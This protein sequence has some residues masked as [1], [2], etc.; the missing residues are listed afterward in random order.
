MSSAAV[1][2]LRR[3]AAS[4]IS[5]APAPPVSP[6]STTERVRSAATR[7]ASSKRWSRK[8]A[9]RSAA[10]GRAG[11]TAGSGG[12]GY[13]T[14]GISAATRQARKKCET[15]S[16]RSSRDEGS[17]PKSDGRN[18]GAPG[19]ACRS[20][21]HQIAACAIAPGRAALHGKN[22][23]TRNETGSASPASHGARGPIA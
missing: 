11:S 4:A 9:H 2:P 20:V 15:L 16:S 8:R 17:N 19:S 21:R 6:S 10:A 14:I 7:S 1:P 23:T 13:S 12:P 5:T 18:A 22:P 3:G